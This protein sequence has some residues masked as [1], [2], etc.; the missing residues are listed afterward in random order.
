M[1]RGSPQQGVVG[2]EAPIL[3][4]QPASVSAVSCCFCVHTSVHPP[5]L[6]QLRVFCAHNQHGCQAATARLERPRS[7]C[8][9]QD[10]AFLPLSTHRTPAGGQAMAEDRAASGHP[11]LR[12]SGAR[13]SARPPQ[14]RQ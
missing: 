2:F 11:Q 3:E 1:E 8:L 10:C 12:V 7:A 14:R 5:S 9:V 13:A 6:N 4:D